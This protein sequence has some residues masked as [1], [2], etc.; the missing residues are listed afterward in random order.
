MEIYPAPLSD[1]K[2]EDLSRLTFA[3]ADQYQD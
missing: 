3:V 1:T 2:S